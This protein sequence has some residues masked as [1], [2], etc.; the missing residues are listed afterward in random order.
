MAMQQQQ[1]APR[2]MY[3]VHMQVCVHAL[4]LRVHC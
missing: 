1:Q 3:H 2:T 4:A